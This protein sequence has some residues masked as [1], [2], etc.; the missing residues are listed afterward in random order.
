MKAYT[1]ALVILW[2]IVSLLDAKGEYMYHCVLVFKLYS[3]GW[4]GDAM[5]LGNLPVPGR[6]TN[7]D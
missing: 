6:P 4:P 3:R 1:I 7:L 5:M 2:K